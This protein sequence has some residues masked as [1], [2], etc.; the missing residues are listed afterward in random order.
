M[1][2][3]LIS[4]LSDFGTGSTPATCRGVMWSI[5]PEARLLDLT[6]DVRRFAVRDGAFLLSRAVGYLPVGVHLAVVDPGVGT[7]RRPVV[8]RA[9]RGDLLVGPDNGLL[10]PAARELGG[11][12][13]AWEITNRD[14]CLPTV[15]STFH[16][17]DL[18]APVAAHLAGGMDPGRVGPLVPFG[19]LVDLRF[20]EATA[21]DG[22]LDTAVLLIDHFGNVR[23]AGR[24]VDLAVIGGPLETGRTFRVIAGER[25]LD[26]PWHASFGEVE[27]GALLMYEDADYGGL[28]I[29]VNQASAAERI[30]LAIDT[31]VRIEPA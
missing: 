22:G 5:A 9:A 24:P 29:A 2:G 13:D 14:L 28:G 27:P 31:P 20:P 8:V 19:S 30:G 15:S 6:H 1:A 16:G 3:P 25:Q 21:R 11:A 10:L 7:T 18:F 12:T 17:R 26:V 23:L 4:F